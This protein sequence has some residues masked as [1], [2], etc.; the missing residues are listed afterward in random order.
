MD[1]LLAFDDGYAPHAAALC[2]S[3]IANNPRRTF[4]FHVFFRTLGGGNRELLQAWLEGKGQKTCFYE[5][6]A[7]LCAHFLVPQNGYFTEDSYFRLL[8]AELLPKHIQRI[9]YLDPD[10]VTLKSLAELWDTDL[11]GYALAAVQASDPERM[12]QKQELPALSGNALNLNAGVLLI[13]L[14]YWRDNNVGGQLSDF[15]RTLTQAPQFVDQDVLNAV[16]VGRWKELPL[17]YNRRWLIHAPSKMAD[18]VICHF[19]GAGRQKPWYADSVSP[20]KDLYALYRRGT[21][22]GAAPLPYYESRPIA[23]PETAVAENEDGASNGP[24]SKSLGA[25]GRVKRGAK[26]AIKRVGGFFLNPVINRIANRTATRYVEFAEPRF[27]A[28]MEAMEKRMN[29]CLGEMVAFELYRNAADRLEPP[30]ESG[31]AEKQEMATE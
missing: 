21:P 16:L 10:I 5:V 15:C 6:P 9:L 2:N 22:W 1:I 28:A 18:T 11:R 4:S 12:K 13:N 19:T 7:E 20:Y 31:I 24:R 23:V 17:K 29:A 30:P 3:L 14:E 26:N 8:C 25:L 27:F